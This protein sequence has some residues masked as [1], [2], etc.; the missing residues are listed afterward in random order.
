MCLWP[1]RKAGWA[2]SGG[3]R[4]SFPT[5]ASAF[6]TGRST[7]TSRTTSLRLCELNIHSA[8]VSGAA[9]LGALAVVA[10]VAVARPFRR[11]RLRW[12]GT[13]G[14]RLSR[15][16]LEFLV[17]AS[18][19]D[20]AQGQ[21]RADHRAADRSRRLFDYPF[22]YII[23]PGFLVFSEEEVAALKHYLLNG[24]FLMVDDFWGD[25]EYQNFYQQMKRVFRRS[26]AGGTPARS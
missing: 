20:F 16:R 19:T 25:Y 13:L 11:W 3:R 2:G 1:S 9:A 17:P 26:R 15:Q 10:V 23:E 22:I 7:S 24:G 12:L 18:A 8:A 4:E 6:P 21:P 5:I 14:D